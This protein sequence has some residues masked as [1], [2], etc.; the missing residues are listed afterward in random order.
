[1]ATLVTENVAVI[2]EESRA[3]AVSWAAI[4]AGGVAAAG[5]SLF[6]FQLGA[7]I[8]LSV[9]SP[10]SSASPSATTMSVAAGIS[11]CLISIMGSALGGFIAGRLRTRW[12][13]L[14]T[15]ET[16]FRDTA[17]GFLAW[18][19]ALILGAMVAAFA[20]SSVV[21]GA[22]QGAASNPGLV[23][24]TSYY[25]DML[26]R[27]QG[28]ANAPAGQPAQNGQTSNDDI[29]RIMARGMTRG[30]ALT[31]EDRSYIVQRVAAR[32]GLSQEEAQRR[33]DTVVTQAKIAADEARKAA[34]KTA[35]W[36]AAAMLCGALAA[37]FAAAAG[38]RERDD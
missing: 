25:T 21:G 11:L 33:V 15:D 17:H 8:G 31:T 5:F 1:M 32:T 6:L 16:Y 13:G 2:P 18:A 23:P 36:M 35:F 38:G 14:H 12:V 24:D 20:A 9:V 26:F 34:A 27:A 10:W 19:F 3:S 37:A 22:T 29:G 30:G 28:P 4:A 7:G